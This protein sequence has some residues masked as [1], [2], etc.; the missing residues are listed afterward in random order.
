VCERDAR[1]GASGL[2]ALG[3]GHL[4]R[5]QPILLM[6]GSGSDHRDVSVE[7]TLIGRTPT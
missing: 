6:G 3:G 5:N 2:H 1:V 4:D 7:E